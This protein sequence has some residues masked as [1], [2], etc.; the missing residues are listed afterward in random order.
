MGIPT[1]EQ[2][3]KGKKLTLEA[4]ER[5]LIEY[6][7]IIH[8]RD[9]EITFLKEKLKFQNEENERHRRTEENLQQ[10]INA[11]MLDK[12]QLESR[13]SDPNGKL[14]DTCVQ[15]AGAEQGFNNQL[16]RMNNEFEKKITSM[17]NE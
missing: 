11:L 6:R 14:E 17:Q 16:V 15:S 1:N 13:I 10:R 5:V 9:S 8:E 7:N 12:K 4:D 3:L 2:F